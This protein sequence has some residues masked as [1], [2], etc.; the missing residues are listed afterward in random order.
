MPRIYCNFLNLPLVLNFLGTDFQVESGGFLYKLEIQVT[1]GR[2][3][4]Y[5]SGKYSA[6][7]TF[8]HCVNILGCS[9][10]A[11]IV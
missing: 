9:N 3:L 7:S 11:G 5:P 6:M 4:C 8:K 1:C 2:V 10:G